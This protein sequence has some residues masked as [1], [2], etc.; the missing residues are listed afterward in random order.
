M[1]RRRGEVAGLIV[2]LEGGAAVGADVDVGAG[3]E[4]G[5]MDGEGQ[6]QAEGE[7]EGPDARMDGGSNGDEAGAVGDDGNG[8]DG[9][10]GRADDDTDDIGG[11]RGNGADQVVDDMTSPAGVDG[12]Q[13]N[14][15]GRE[16]DDV[17]HLGGS[18]P[19]HPG[20]DAQIDDEEE[21]DDM[22]EVS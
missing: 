18:A 16:G 1:E 22:E 8:G 15:I 9:L 17:R 7:G 20:Q 6:K 14:D 13:N 12:G 2:G 5:A 21:D 19:G 10:A 11:A 3:D 4:L